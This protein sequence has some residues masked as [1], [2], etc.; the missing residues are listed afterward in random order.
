MVNGDNN[1]IRNATGTVAEAELA[2]SVPNL[3]ISCLEM[4]KAGEIIDKESEKKNIDITVEATQDDDWNGSGNGGGY[5]NIS[6]DNDTICQNRKMQE[7]ERNK[8]ARRW[9]PNG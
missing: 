7:R 1:S 3:N 9:D 5:V 4:N 2:S 6:M 8:N